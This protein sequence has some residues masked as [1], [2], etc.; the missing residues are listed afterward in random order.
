MLELRSTLL[1]SRHN[2]SKIRIE[3]GAGREE[4]TT[5][6]S[7]ATFHV[8][9][10]MNRH[11]VRIWNSGNPYHEMELTLDCSKVNVWGSNVTRPDDRSFLFL[12]KRQ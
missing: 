12:L 11:D 2:V 9:G 4:T 3:S 7:E 5:E 1:S 8:C 6:A 10:R